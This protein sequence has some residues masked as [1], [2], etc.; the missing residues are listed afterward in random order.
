LYLA[1][2]DITFPDQLIFSSKL[3]IE[4]IDNQIHIGKEMPHIWPLLPVMKEAKVALNQII[5][6]IKE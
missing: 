5:K 4:K 6:N 3:N 1:E 2:N